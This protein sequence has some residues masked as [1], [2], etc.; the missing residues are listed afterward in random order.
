MTYRRRY[1]FWTTHSSPSHSRCLCWRANQ[2]LRG[3]SDFEFSREH[4]NV[5]PAAR[6]TPRCYPRLERKRRG[7]GRDKE[8]ESTG[9]GGSTGAE[10]LSDGAALLDARGL[11]GRSTVG[12]RDAAEPRSEVEPRG[13]S[14]LTTGGR[15]LCSRRPLL[16]LVPCCMSAIAQNTLILQ[17]TWKAHRVRFWGSLE[18]ELT[19][20]A[21]C[22][23]F[24]PTQRWGALGISHILS[25]ENTIFDHVPRVLDTAFPLGSLIESDSWRAIWNTS[26]ESRNCALACIS[27]PRHSCP[28]NSGSTRLI[29]QCLG[30]E[31]VDKILRRYTHESPRCSAASPL[32][33]KNG[34]EYSP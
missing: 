8:G 31:M 3:P 32:P 12:V 29:V 27:S 7:T 5:D 25:V 20:D 6:K 11:S 4:G 21:G 24:R 13:R 17:N 16:S 30:N 15:R 26:L 19:V 33:S 34:H 22:L 10:A 1:F 9:K 23:C 28:M 2:D 14:A 18:N